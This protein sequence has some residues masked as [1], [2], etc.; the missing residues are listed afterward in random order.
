MFIDSSQGG[1]ASLFLFMG[2]HRTGAAFRS[3]NADGIGLEKRTAN[4]MRGF[5][6]TP[7]FGPA[8][9]GGL[10]G[11]SSAVAI[12]IAQSL[13]GCIEHR[14]LVAQPKY[15]SLVSQL[16]PPREETGELEI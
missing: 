1:S 9:L 5:P 12:R 14:Y 4:L 15:A 3:V 10:F 11:Q 8:V 13:A 16:K 7:F 6:G 2:A